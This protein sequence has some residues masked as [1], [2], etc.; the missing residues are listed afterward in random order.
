MRLGNKPL[1]IYFSIAHSIACF[2]LFFSFSVFLHF[3]VVH[4]VVAHIKGID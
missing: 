4:N 2:V 3:A 1:Q